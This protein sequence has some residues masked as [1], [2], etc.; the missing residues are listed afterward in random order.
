MAP[1]SCPWYEPC[2]IPG[3][4]R[5][6]SVLPVACHDMHLFQQRKAI[7]SKSVIFLLLVANVIA[8]FTNISAVMRESQRL[9]QRKN[10]PWRLSVS[11]RSYGRFVTTRA[12]VDVT[13]AGMVTFTSLPSRCH[14]G[15]TAGDCHLRT[16]VSKRRHDTR[17]L[18][19]PGTAN[20]PIKHV[21]HL[22]SPSGITG[23]PSGASSSVPASNS[24]Q[25]GN[26]KSRHRNEHSLASWS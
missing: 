7:E 14:W 13:A 17:W 4:W 21:Y 11:E 6:T 1:S 26:F 18:S 10:R 23:P 9:T 19:P 5:E 22:M 3:Q 12:S 24:K 16:G 2:H 25:K 8:V 15:S 20:T